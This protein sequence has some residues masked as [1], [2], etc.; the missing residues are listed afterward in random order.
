MKTVKVTHID[1]G[2]HGYLSVSKKDFI[3]ICSPMNI[4]GYSG[5]N[6]TRIYLEEDSDATKFFEACEKEGIVP[7]VKS[8]YN[9]KFNCTHNYKP[10]LF[11]W[12]PEI[13]AQ[14]KMHDEL[15]YTIITI[16]DEKAIVSGNGRK[17]RLPLNEP[18]KWFTD[19]RPAETPEMVQ[20]IN[21]L[22]LY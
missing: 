21:Q 20:A 7:V 22:N 3:G 15:W 19:A 6:L 10:E 8:S 13:G 18:F 9:L 4:S 2:G 12:L 16:D 1:T 17:Y 5:H 11:D 14:I